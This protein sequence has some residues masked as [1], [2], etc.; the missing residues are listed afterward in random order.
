MLPSPKI[1]YTPVQPKVDS[2]YDRFEKDYVLPKI[3][4]GTIIEMPWTA[5]VGTLGYNKTYAMKV[6]TPTGWMVGSPW[7]WTRMATTGSYLAR[8]VQHCYPSYNS[9]LAATL[10]QDYIVFT[11]GGQTS[12]S[13]YSAVNRN[14]YQ[15]SNNGSG[16]GRS[17]PTFTYYDPLNYNVMQVRPYSPAEPAAPVRFVF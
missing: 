5:T 8:V 17:F 9:F 16:A 10:R 1:F 15:S 4:N 14:S 7:A 13:T 6:Q 2:E 12:T 11:T 3:A